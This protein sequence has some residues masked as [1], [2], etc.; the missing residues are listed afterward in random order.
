M[1]K[2]IRLFGLLSFIFL[3][4]GLLMDSWP[5][6]AQGFMVK[7]MKMELQS[8]AGQTVEEVLELRNITAN[9]TL[10]LDLKLMELTQSKTGGW[11]VI[12]PGSNIDTSNLHSC[13]EWIR[14]S[15]ETV[16]IKPLEM[17]PVKVNLRIPRRARGFYAAA[18]LVQ[19]RP[20]K[21]KEGRIRIG[22]VVRF[23]IPVLVEIQGRLVRQK[24]ELT[25][26][27]MQ[28]LEQSE[29]NPATTLVLMD[30]VNKGGTY[31]RLEGNIN[32]MR[33]LGQH[34]QRI[35][36]AEFGEVGII[37]GVELNLESDLKR[38]LPS[39]KYKLMGT[40][41]VDGRRIKPLVKEIDF[42][43]DPTVTK[44]AADI[45]LTLDPSIL[46]IK[47]VPGGTRAAT[48]KI[49]NLSE[50]AVNVSVDVEVPKSFRGLSL[51]ELKGEDF[52]CAGW[53]KVIPDNFTLRAG[54][55]QNIR[56]IAK[57]PRSEKMYA[58]YYATLNFHTTY[59]DGR[60]GGKNTSLIWLKNAK[61]KAKP[62]AQI[63][64]VSLAAEEDSRYIIRTK[65]GNV[66]NV[67]FNPKCN[68]IV[69]TPDGTPMLETGLSGQRQIMLPLEI[70]DFSGI[71]DF[72]TAEEGIYR[73]AVLM[74]Y[75][76]KTKQ[77]SKILPIQ[78]S[79]EEGKKIVTVIPVN[80]K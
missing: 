30:V 2:K 8:R 11:W 28:F 65:S 71:L 48:I 24:I 16:E 70:R 23:L 17:V 7:P 9:K 74:D 58:N 36:Q 14:L 19:T 75:G 18:L 41:Y 29:K 47:S 13:L 12:E 38:Q 79:I 62:V 51:G 20:S 6:H 26:A 57:L 5:A 40:L 80:E 37:P 76:A 15:A 39:G 63:I 53:T 34:W 61:I 55:H 1:K 64:K 67:H 33:Q 25:D 44:V 59:T 54:R 49:W 77:I 42:I 68:A 56:I 35:S 4:E 10:T 27:D 46:S 78:V 22:I 66:G 43:G 21:P 72:S 31:S 50:E 45:P 32:V 60:S 52:T 69:T 3:I 73:L